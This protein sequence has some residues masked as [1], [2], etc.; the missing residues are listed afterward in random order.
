VSLKVIRNVLREYFVWILVLQVDVLVLAQLM[1]WSLLLRQKTITVQSKYFCHFELL[2]LS[3][4]ELE[5]RTGQ[6]DTRT[7]YRQ[8]DRQTDPA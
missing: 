8:T 7:V 3:V 1:S 4:F 2:G 5:G 6:T